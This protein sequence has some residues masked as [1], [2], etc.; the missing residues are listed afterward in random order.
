MSRGRLER[1]Q[2]FPNSEASS[3]GKRSTSWVNAKDVVGRS[4]STPAVKNRILRGL[5][6]IRLDRG[7][8]MVITMVTQGL[9]Q[10][11]AAGESI[12]TRKLK[13][14][15]SLRDTEYDGLSNA[16][17]FTSKTSCQCGGLKYSL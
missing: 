2:G 6:L 10:E 7:A 14:G 8:P 16:I 5:G 15:R 3:R 4:H 17:N 11:M 1:C 9:G 13:H 12:W